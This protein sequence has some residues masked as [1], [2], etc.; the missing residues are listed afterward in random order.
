MFPSPS[1]PTPVT[2]SLAQG[3]GHLGIIHNNLGR[4][5]PPLPVFL[6]LCL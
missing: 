2:G 1:K 6:W 5:S 4:Q 3:Q